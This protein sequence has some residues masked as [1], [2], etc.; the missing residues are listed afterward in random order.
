MTA[1]PLVL[2][3]SISGDHGEGSCA[4]F[5]AGECCLR[6]WIHSPRVN[7]LGIEIEEAWPLVLFL[8]KVGKD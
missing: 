4:F 8:C 7:F 6:G 3:T 5:N 2:L 1:I